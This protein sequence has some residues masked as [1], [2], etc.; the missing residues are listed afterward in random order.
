MGRLRSRVCRPCRATGSTSS[1][2]SSRISRIGRGSCCTASLSSVRNSGW[3]PGCHTQGACRRLPGGTDGQAASAATTAVHNRFGSLSSRSR[4]TQAVSDL[5]DLS[6]L[7]DPVLAW[8][9]SARSIVL[10]YPAGA[11]TSA[12][13]APLAASRSS[14]SPA[15]TTNSGGSCGTAI[16]A[17]GTNDIALNPQ[18]PRSA[19]TV[20]QLPR[21]WAGGLVCCAARRSNTDGCVAVACHATIVVRGD[22]VH[23][24]RGFRTERVA[25][26]AT[27]HCKHA[28]CSFHCNDWTTRAHAFVS[29]REW[30]TT[31]APAE[32]LGNRRPPRRI[33]G[34]A[35][36][37]GI[38]AAGSIR[39]ESPLAHLLPY[40]DIVD[41]PLRTARPR[42]GRPGISR[43]TR[44]RPGP[45]LPGPA[46]GQSPRAP[47][48]V[49]GTPRR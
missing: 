9:Q 36:K 39:D 31:C 38:A 22:R 13:S 27:I 21:H 4:L 12:T 43:R 23:P 44:P 17:S 7:S 32:S 47:S 45:R 24:F 48:R 6:D 18:W 42:I 2:T 35:L 28:R 11:Q 8:A 34:S 30:S 19:R 1:C 40:R 33:C 20:T 3:A 29:D 16:F 15:R 14:R 10:P 5:S 25:R 41:E 26:A 46:P 37:K 49:R